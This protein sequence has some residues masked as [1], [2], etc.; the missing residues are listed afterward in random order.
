MKVLVAAR[1]SKEGV[2]K[3]KEKH[4][5]ETAYDL[6]ESELIERI[7]TCDAVV[8]RSK[9]KITRKVIEAGERLKVVGRAGVGLDN[10]D[11]EAAKE[12]GV[13]VVN[14]PTASSE[15]VAELVFA[16]SLSLVR[17][18]SRA[19]SSLRDKKWIKKELKGTE[20]YE[21]AMG[22]IGYGR[23]GAHVAKIAGG[24]GMDCMAYDVVKNEELAEK[25]NVAYKELDEVLKESDVITVHVPLISQTK[26]MIGEEEF[27]KMKNSA[28]LVNAARGGVVDEKALYDALK[29][30]EIRGAA[31]DVYETEPPYDSPLLKLKNIVFSQHLGANTYEAQRK[32]GTIIAERIIEEL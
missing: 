23:I 10:I 11:L 6:S 22:I 8:V 1:I 13:K 21:K 14:S 24:F 27:K 4:E 32:N 3:L 28:V 12:N 5:V 29:T 18:I 7:Q 20:L 31:L 25:Y 19:D 16:L 15:S 30:E 26:H 9:P 17:G 2:E